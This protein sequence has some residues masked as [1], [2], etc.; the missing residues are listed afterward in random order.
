MN[1][2][3]EFISWKVK[4]DG[5]INDMSIIISEANNNRLIDAL[6]D[7]ATNP[8]DKDNQAYFTRVSV[9]TIDAYLEKEGWYK[10]MAEDKDEQ[11]SPYKQDAADAYSAR[12]GI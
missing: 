9:E 5:D 4:M 10:L 6:I 7:V 2:V 11:E 1:R 8:S 3:A 12:M